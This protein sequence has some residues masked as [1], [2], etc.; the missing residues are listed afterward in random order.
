MKRVFTITINHRIKALLAVVGLFISSPTFACG[1]FFCSVLP[2]NQA[3][4][5]IIFRQDGSQITTMVRIQYSGEAESFGWVL[6]VPNTPELSLGDDTI[7]NQLEALTR[8]QFNLTRT[9]EACPVVVESSGSGT[10]A[11]PAGNEDFSQDDGVNV[12]QRLTIGAF[13]AQIISSDSS[14]ALAIWLADNNLDLSDRGAELLEPYINAN[15]KFVVLNLQSTANVGDIQPII[16]KYEGEKPMIPLKLTAVAAEDDMGILVWL[17]GDARAVPE[18]FLH[19]TPNYTRLNWYTGPNNAYVSYQSLITEAMDEAG[20]Q[21]FATDYAGVFENLT[22]GLSDE[23]IYDSI[24]G[25]SET[26]SSAEYLQ[27]VWRWGFDQRIL[28]LFNT[29]LPLPEGQDTSVYGDAVALA[30][31]YTEAELSAADSN[32]REAIVDRLAEPLANSLDILDDEL[33]LTRLYTTLSPEEML[34]DPTFAFNPDM[35]D[36]ALARN[37]TLD[38][39]CTSEGTEWTLTLGE[40]TGR[41][42]ELVIDGRGQPPVAA[43]ATTQDATWQVAETSA[44]GSATVV[45]DN[46]F[47]V[48][49]SGQFESS[50]SRSDSGGGGAISWMIFALLSLLCWQGIRLIARH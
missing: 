20:G 44:V 35:P 5:Q 10:A 7:F 28:S 16:L 13:Q 46:D 47:S 32:I 39:N 21:G 2:I 9:G 45:D 27:Q 30:T 40:G 23:N 34:V 33:Y 1:G 12:E 8:P 26:V 18:N 41:S 15:M 11:S 24:V 48:A 17:L 22:D 38:A 3:G 42:D 4:E 49:Q 29:L 31:Q 37:A 25:I 43:V 50:S 14:Q 6:P 36:Q 19:V